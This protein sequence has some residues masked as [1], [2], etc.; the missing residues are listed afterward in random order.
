MYRIIRLTISYTILYNFRLFTCT[1]Y[2][3]YFGHNWTLIQISKYNQ[4]FTQPGPH[5]TLNFAQSSLNSCLVFMP[6]HRSS[7]RGTLSNQILPTCIPYMLH[8]YL[9]VYMYMFTYML[10]TLLTTH[11]ELAVIASYSPHCVD[12]CLQRLQ[13]GL[14]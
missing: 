4:T 3:F 13:Q 10:D 5:L 12:L 6:L 2:V 7:L 9:H 11:L 14:T 1:N 8:V